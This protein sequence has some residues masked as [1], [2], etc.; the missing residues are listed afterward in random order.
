MYLKNEST[1]NILQV[2]YGENT[3]KDVFNVF[4]NLNMTNRMT[5]HVPDRKIQ[6]H[7]MTV[8]SNLT[9]TLKAMPI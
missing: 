6:Y 5:H 3:L 8:S 7:K 9:N 4:N 2:P 1:L